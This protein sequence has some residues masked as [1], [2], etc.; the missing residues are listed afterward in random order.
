VIPALTPQVARFV[1]DPTASAVLVAARSTVGAVNFGSTEISGSVEV[2]RT[3]SRLDLS[4]RP[5]ARLTVPL[6]SLTSGNALYD[7]ELSQRLG[8]QRW[9]SVT[10]ELVDAQALTGDTYHVKGTMTLRDVTA[11]LAGQVTLTFPDRDLV[12]VTGEQVIDI[13]DFGIE[14]PSVLM[15][16]IYPEVTVSLHLLATESGPIGEAP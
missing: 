1:V 4:V 3:G 13:R 5:S 11:T 8:A 2:V 15:L 7:A 9:P 12:F 10:I 14:V 6:A 16:R